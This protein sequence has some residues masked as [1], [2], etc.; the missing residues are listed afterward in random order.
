MTNAFPTSEMSRKTAFAVPWHFFIILLFFCS[1]FF[2]MSSWNSNQS[3][4]GFQRRGHGTCSHPPT[5]PTL[6]ESLV[7]LP[8]NASQTT[9]AIFGL[10]VV[11]FRGILWVMRVAGNI[12]LFILFQSSPCTG[13]CG[14]ICEWMTFCFPPHVTL[15]SGLRSRPNGLYIWYLRCYH[16]QRQLM[17]QSLRAH[18]LFYVSAQ[19]TRL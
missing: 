3:T 18:L 16:V 2:S 9:P 10:A 7:G 11:I 1:S 13:H 15:G 12:Q 5:A 8:A 19:L 17:I 4:L 6:A 14:I